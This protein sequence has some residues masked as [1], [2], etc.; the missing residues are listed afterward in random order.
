VRL[1]NFETS[2]HQA[3]SPWQRLHE[4]WLMVHS[5]DEREEPVVLGSLTSE[6]SLWRWE[7]SMSCDVGPGDRRWW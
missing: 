2:G 1:D 3:R 4:A 5:Q 6:G 7:Q